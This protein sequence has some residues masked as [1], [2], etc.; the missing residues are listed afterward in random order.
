MDRF[1]FLSACSCSSAAGS[2]YGD[3]DSAVTKD[4]FLK[5]RM[6]RASAG[7]AFCPRVLPHKCDALFR[8][9]DSDVSNRRIRMSASHCLCRCNVPARACGGVDSGIQRRKYRT[10]L[11]FCGHDSEVGEHRGR[12][13]V[14]SHRP[15]LHNNHFQIITH[16][17]DTEI[18]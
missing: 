13:A 3:S 17:Y 12:C 4:S 2:D 5:S 1:S 18:H 14:H 15:V 7:D 8:N 16:S 10:I 11:W 9:A 6:G